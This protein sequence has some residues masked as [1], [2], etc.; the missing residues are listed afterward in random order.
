VKRSAL[1]PAAAAGEKSGDEPYFAGMPVRAVAAGGFVARSRI[2]AP[3]GSDSRNNRG[4]APSRTS[5]AVT[6]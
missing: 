2:E 6:E 3:V 1:R 4:G 5:S